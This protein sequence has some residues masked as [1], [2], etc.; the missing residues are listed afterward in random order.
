MPTSRT[1]EVRPNI[2]DER[3]YLIALFGGEGLLG[4]LERL[5]VP[6]PPPPHVVK[7]LF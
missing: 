1:R 2:D 4:K 3:R 6:P 5:K 7:S